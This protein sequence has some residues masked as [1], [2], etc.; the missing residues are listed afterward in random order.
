MI[1]AIDPGVTG[2]LAFSYGGEVTVED[3]PTTVVTKNGKNRTH[4]NLEQLG[5][6]LRA[7]I[8][9][10]HPVVIIEQVGP[11]PRDGSIQAFSLGRGFGILEGMVTALGG[12][13]IYVTPQKWKRRLGVTSDKDTSLQLARELFP[14]LSEQLKLKKNHGR[15]EALLLMHYAINC[16]EIAFTV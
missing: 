8:V 16:V 2:A 10:D 1:I 13:L 15:A 9:G 11:M 6:M 14:Q 7:T 4:Y 12:T 3:I 5:E